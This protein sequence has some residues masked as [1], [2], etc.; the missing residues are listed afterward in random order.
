MVKLKCYTFFL[1][2]RAL[3]KTCPLLLIQSSPVPKQQ[4]GFGPTFLECF[5]EPFHIFKVI[6]KRHE[7][8][9]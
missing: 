6:A 2:N 7:K 9:L 5:I 1:F 8:T 3:R 4:R